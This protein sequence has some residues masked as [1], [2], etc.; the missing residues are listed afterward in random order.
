[1]VTVKTTNQM[2][3]SLMK[4]LTTNQNFYKSNFHFC[5][6]SVDCMSSVSSKNIF[7]L[8]KQNF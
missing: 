6:F 8:T 4:Y 1:M 7:M 5:T 2:Y 3:K